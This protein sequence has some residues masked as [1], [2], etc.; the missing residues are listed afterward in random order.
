[1]SEFDI[2]CLESSFRSQNVRFFYQ[3][4]NGIWAATSCVLKIQIQILICRFNKGTKKGLNT[5][6]PE[7][8]AFFFPFLQ[9]ANLV[10]SVAIA[11]FHFEILSHV[12]QVVSES[13]RKS[14]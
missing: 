13:G 9:L 3:C 4:S 6:L 5:N 12:N 2:F 8:A 10:V 7:K 1:M 11:V 14:R